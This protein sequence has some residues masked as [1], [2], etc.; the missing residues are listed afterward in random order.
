[1]VLVLVRLYE[2]VALVS[3]GRLKFETGVDEGAKESVS[4]TIR[5]HEPFTPAV[6]LRW[7]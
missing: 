2:S 4:K 3:S 7:F 5:F 1:M 6:V